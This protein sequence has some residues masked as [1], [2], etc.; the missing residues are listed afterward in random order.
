M[1]GLTEEQSRRVKQQKMQKKNA[2]QRILGDEDTAGKF[3]HPLNSVQKK[4]PITG[5]PNGHPKWLQP[6]PTKL[7]II[8]QDF[9]L[10]R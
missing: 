8:S 10:R 9:M 3:H 6:A 1:T 5:N 2:E 4:G 7:S